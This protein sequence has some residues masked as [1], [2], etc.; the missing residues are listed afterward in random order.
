MTLATSFPLLFSLLFVCVVNGVC[1]TLTYVYTSSSVRATRTWHVLSG[2]VRSSSFHHLR[3]NNP[4]KT[5]QFCLQGKYQI[6]PK[7]PFAPGGEVAG[8]VSALG[9]GCTRWGLFLLSRL[10]LRKPLEGSI[11]TP[12]LLPCAR[13][14]NTLV[15]CVCTA[16]LEHLRL[17]CSFVFGVAASLEP[18]VFQSR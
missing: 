18:K 7:F 11:F 17:L 1:C 6:R 9:D 14:T 4:N 8:V 16:V 10:S 12:W 15:T 5:E 2:L 13:H 3:I